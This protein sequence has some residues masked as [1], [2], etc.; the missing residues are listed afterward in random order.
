[1]ASIETTPELVQSVYATTRKRLAIIR[2][3]LGRPLHLRV[4]VI[5]GSV[6]RWEGQAT[7]FDPYVGPCYRCLFPEPPPPEFA[8]NCAEAGVLGVLPGVIGSIQATEALKRVLGVG[9]GLVG[10]FLTYDALA[11]EFTT[12]HIERDPSCPAC[13]DE[14]HP[15]ALV[16]YD[17]AC[18]YGGAVERG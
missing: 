2:E 12:L 9:E 8:P 18:R 10:R 16:D 15:P 4:P 1:M 3:R 14:A 13:S 17:D 7:V 5:H 11:Q 6:F